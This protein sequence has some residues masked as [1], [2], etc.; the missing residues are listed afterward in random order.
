MPRNLYRAQT[1]LAMVAAIVGYWLLPYGAFLS[2]PVF[3]VGFAAAFLF[4]RRR[5]GV[6]TPQPI[7]RQSWIALAVVLALMWGVLI[8]AVSF[9]HPPS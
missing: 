3:G 1:V 9:A 8:P 2:L 6:I 4:N 7:T 5:F